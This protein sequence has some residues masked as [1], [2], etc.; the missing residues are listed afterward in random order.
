MTNNDSTDLILWH[1]PMQHQAKCHQNPR[2][3]GRR[4]NQQPQKAQPSL[5]IPS[6]PDIHQAARERGAEERDG[7]HRG[8]AEEKGGGVKEEPRELGWGAAGGFFEEA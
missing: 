8:E 4:K 3:I 2:Q 6:A 1:S 7:E 5:R